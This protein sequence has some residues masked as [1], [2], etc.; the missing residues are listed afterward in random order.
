MSPFGLEALSRFAGPS[1]SG[2]KGLGLGVLGPFAGLG[3]VSRVS[4]IGIRAVWG[5]GFRDW[6][7]GLLGAK[8]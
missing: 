3:V 4:G 7:S 6:G 5:L 8:V 1:V 2:L